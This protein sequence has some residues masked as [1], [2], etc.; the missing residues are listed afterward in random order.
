LWEHR[1]ERTIS[2]RVGRKNGDSTKNAFSVNIFLDFL[3]KNDTPSNRYVSARSELISHKIICAFVPKKSK[4]DSLKGCYWGILSKINGTP[5]EG[6]CCNG[7]HN[8]YTS[9]Q[10]VQPKMPC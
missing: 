9:L 7:T 8:A 6:L 4:E 1:S 10:F 3:I 5:G 2:D